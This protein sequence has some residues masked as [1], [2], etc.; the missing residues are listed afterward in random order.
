MEREGGRD[1]AAACRAWGVMEGPRLSLG[2]APLPWGCSLP[3]AAPRPCLGV[4]AWSCPGSGGTAGL[5]AVCSWGSGI[6]PGRRP[7]QT[8][9]LSSL[10]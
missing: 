1:N 7:A 10:Q 8:P 4:C 5:G 2:C 3:P 9:G 6:H